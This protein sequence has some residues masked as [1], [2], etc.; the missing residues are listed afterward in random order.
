MDIPLLSGTLLVGAGGWLAYNAKDFGQK[1]FSFVR[2]RIGYTVE[3]SSN[4]IELFTAV[5]AWLGSVEERARFLDGHF[6][7]KNRGYGEFMLTPRGAYILKHK[8]RRILVWSTKEAVEMSD[9]YRE[10]IIFQTL[11]GNREVFLDIMKTA[12]EYANGL[13]LGLVEILVPDN[14]SNN[15][16][17]CEHKL[18]RRADTLCLSGEV[19]GIFGDAKHFLSERD[20][21]QKMNIPF[22]RG[23]LLHGPPG[24]GK[25]SVVHALATELGVG[26]NVA[27]IS[28]F[29][30]DQNFIAIRRY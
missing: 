16:R 5:R 18:P 3:I 26:I 4:E 19:T 29:R 7:E 8:G 6:I 2:S 12:H 27:N 14:Y 24:N 17:T 1:A 21:Y 15:W 28:S 30:S 20:W 22:R 10:K 23:Y 11:F 25:S 13:H 9:T